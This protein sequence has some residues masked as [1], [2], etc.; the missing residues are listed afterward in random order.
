MKS[1][2]SKFYR[3]DESFSVNIHI[4]LCIIWAGMM[5]I[6]YIYIHVIKQLLSTAPD[7]KYFLSVNINYGRT[8]YKYCNIS[9]YIYFW[10]TYVDLDLC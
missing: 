10:N 4:L 6:T 1:I 8:P 3:N 2:N 9:L 5:P 7:K